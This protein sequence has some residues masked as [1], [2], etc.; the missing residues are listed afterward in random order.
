MKKQ[1]KSF[2]QQS[3][4]SYAGL[5]CQRWNSPI[6]WQW[7]VIPF[8]TGRAAKRIIKAT[9]MEI[10]RP[11]QIRV[12]KNTMCFITLI[13]IIQVLKKL[14]QP[15]LGNSTIHLNSVFNSCKAAFLQT[16]IFRILVPSPSAPNLPHNETHVFEPSEASTKYWMFYTNCNSVILEVDFLSYTND[17]LQVVENFLLHFNIAREATYCKWEYRCW[18]IFLCLAWMPLKILKKVKIYSFSYLVLNTCFKTPACTEEKRVL[19]VWFQ[20]EHNF[21]CTHKPSFNSP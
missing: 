9:G 20:F 19:R 1:H 14:H 3:P 2:R 17:L 12:I 15:C 8:I 6:P 21:S 11:L 10:M 4:W 18:E 7:W 13:F 5:S 16:S